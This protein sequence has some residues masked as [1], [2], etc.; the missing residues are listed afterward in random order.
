MSAWPL[1]IGVLTLI[2]LYGAFDELTQ[3][4]VRNREPDLYDWLADLAGALLGIAAY[5]VARQ[6]AFVFHP[7]RSSTSQP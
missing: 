2:A 7:R 6:L 1:I 5:S 3:A 4:F